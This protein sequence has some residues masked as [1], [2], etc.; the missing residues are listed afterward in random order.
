MNSMARLALLLFAI[1]WAVRGLSMVGAQSVDFFKYRALLEEGRWV[2]EWFLQ[3]SMGLT[4]A[5]LTAVVPALLLIRFRGR[6]ADR[7]FPDSAAPSTLT[8]SSGY[9]LGCTLLSLFFMIGGAALFVGGLASALVAIAT[10]SDSVRSGLLPTAA[11]GIASGIVEM[12]L[13]WL[14]YHHASDSPAA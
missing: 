5:F 9:V 14:L 4:A 6:I 12:V 3:F 2:G 11:Q 10:D 8:P 13:G 7:F 1:F